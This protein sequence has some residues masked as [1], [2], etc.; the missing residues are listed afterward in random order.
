[1]S[2]A[3]AVIFHPQHGFAMC[4]GGYSVNGNVEASAQPE[5]GT[6]VTCWLCGRPGVLPDE[7]HELEFA[8]PG[9]ERTP[10]G[11]SIMVRLSAPD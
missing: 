9:S 3:Q 11:R 7:G 4:C 5:H 2:I 10:D 1:M 8:P 6:L